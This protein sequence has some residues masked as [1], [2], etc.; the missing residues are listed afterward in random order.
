MQHDA[1]NLSKKQLAE[2]ASQTAG[3]YLHIGLV[4]STI[5][6]PSSNLEPRNPSSEPDQ[7][8]GSIQISGTVWDGKKEPVK[9]AI[10]EAW[11]PDLYH[12][13]AD[14]SPLADSFERWHRVVTDFDNGNWSINT[15]CPEGF[16]D[17]APS[18]YFWIVARGI[19][20]GLHTR[21]YF[22]ENHI[23]NTLDPV[24][25]AVPPDRRTTLVAQCERESH[26]RFDIVLQGD[27]ETV[28][29]DV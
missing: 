9:D 23:R 14:S 13:T 17:N 22:P 24:L 3:P 29:F 7:N 4:P 1:V 5:G 2:T 18:I 25:S 15:W 26:Y 21:M 8:L 12:A 6:L 19:N 27:N 20:I 10:L 16:G 11:Q 28:F